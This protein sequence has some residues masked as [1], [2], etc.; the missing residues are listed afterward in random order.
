MQLVLV[1]QNETAEQFKDDREF[2]LGKLRELDQDMRVSEYPLGFKFTLAPFLCVF[3]SII[4][5]FL[6]ETSKLL[7][8]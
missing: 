7:Q 5:S 2:F 1:Y 4:K 6:F 3:G 8:W